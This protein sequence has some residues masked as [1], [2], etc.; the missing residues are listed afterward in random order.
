MKII[1][2]ITDSPVDV[3]GI[4]EEML[5]MEATEHWYVN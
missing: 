5:A 4:A 3:P 2:Q 1:S